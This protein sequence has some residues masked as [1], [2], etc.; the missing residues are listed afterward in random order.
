MWI[1]PKHVFVKVVDFFRLQSNS[2]RSRSHLFQL[3]NHLSNVIIGIIWF[4]QIFVIIFFQTI[5]SFMQ[6]QISKQRSFSFWKNL[7]LFHSGL[8]HINKIMEILCPMEKIGGKTICKDFERTTKHLVSNLEK[9]WTEN[10]FQQSTC[11]HLWHILP[12]L[13]RSCGW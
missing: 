10:I 8:Y 6:L 3:S 1:P 9:S 11:L 7:C 5:W 13:M 2:D 4:Q 12:G